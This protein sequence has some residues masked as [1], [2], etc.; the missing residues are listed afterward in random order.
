MGQFA[1]ES[2][3]STLGFSDTGYGKEREG[4][5]LAIKR[6]CSAMGANCRGLAAILTVN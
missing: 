2:G 6:W 5:E 3:A 4:K 1:D